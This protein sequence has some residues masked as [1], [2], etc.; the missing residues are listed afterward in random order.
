[1]NTLFISP[2][3]PW[4][5]DSGGRIRIYHLLRAVAAESKVS[6]LCFTEADAGPI[7]HEVAKLVSETHTVSR[8]TCRYEIDAALSPMRRRMRDLRELFA[9]PTP[10]IVR[11]WHSKQADELT[12]KLRERR[13]DLVWGEHIGSVNLTL[14]FADTR[15][16][17]D[18]YDVEHSKLKHRIANTGASLATPAQYLEYLK[19]RRFEL[20][21]KAEHEVL[22][23]STVD[24]TA[25]NLP[26]DHSVVP[27]G[28]ELP[29][30]N[31]DDRSS[32]DNSFVFIG[33]LNYPPNVDAVHWLCSQ[34][35]PRIRQSLPSAKL[36][37][38]GRSPVDSVRKLHDGDAIN[39]AADVP[40][41]A[42][43]LRT[44][45]A[46]L[47]PI[48][49]G[50]GTRIK[51]LE[52]M[53]HGI[54]IVS[55]T[56]GAEGIDVTPGTDIMIADDP[57]TFAE[58]CVGL[59]HSEQQRKALSIAGRELVERKYQWSSIES[60]VRSFVRNGACAS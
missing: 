30:A 4:P 44:S 48:R 53:A 41:V 52:G 23:C 45:T 3:I 37:I 29:P 40:D 18:L 15:R 1:V 38:V 47:V 8:K 35:F 46:L 43:F 26:C 25:L 39:I 58:R 56:V 14:P 49:F 54:P 20:T 19:L 28:I 6:L 9:D 42:P 12:A 55:S 13:F 17:L 10:E 16:V 33:T 57:E 5:L 59:A 31:N 36:F 32:T 11:M 7:P 50:G 2:S 24:Q 51:I 27:N 22:V 34:I 60:H 21:L